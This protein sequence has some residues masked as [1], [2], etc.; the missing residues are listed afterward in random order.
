MQKLTPFLWFDD[1]AEEAAEFYVEV[2]NSRPGG[3]EESKILGVSRYGEAGPGEPGTAMTATFV[4]EGLEFTA[5][6]GGPE[7]S[8]NEAISFQIDCETQDEVDELWERLAEGGGA[9]RGGWLTDRFG[10]SVQIIPRGLQELLAD[11]DPEK[12]RRAME[13]MLQMGKIDIAE[14]RRAAEG[15]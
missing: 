6:N 7:F 12:S 15:G 8:F 9:G 4:L 5:L 11:P 13:A 1:K 14:V 2:F 10:V 3:S